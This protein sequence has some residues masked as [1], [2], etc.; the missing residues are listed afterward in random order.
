M[1]EV[2]LLALPV[3]GFLVIFLA[4]L[5]LFG[6]LLVDTKG[7]F[8]VIGTGLYIIYFLSVSS[9]MPIY[10]ILVLL[11]AGIIFIILDGKLINHGFVAIIGLLL[12]MLASALPA[13]SFLYGVLVSFGY[14]FG[15]SLS[16]LF[17]KVFHP[18]HFWSR[19]ALFDQLS[20][21]N[22]YNSL[23]NHY[24]DLVGK[25]GTTRTPFRPIGTI[26]VDGESYSATTNGY[27]LEP[28]TAIK[29]ISVDGTKIVVQQI[30][31]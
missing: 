19:V 29:V 16:F 15:V 12:V 30:N 22:G 3:G 23:N 31:D 7:I 21:E 6:E 8:A 27:W 4:S 14:L 2:G 10:L 18:R 9:T 26:V 5:F 13:P 20:S 1:N 28:E 24:K 17:L 11:V 25:E